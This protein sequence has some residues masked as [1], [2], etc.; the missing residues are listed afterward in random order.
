MYKLYY[1]PSTASL[2]VH[3]MLIELKVDFELVLVDFGTKAQK[4]AE[5][6]RINPSGHVPTLVL[7]GVPHFEC[8]ALLML[9][10]ERH[11]EAGFQPSIGTPERP[12][13]FQ[14]MFYLANTLQPAFRNWFY[15]EEA[16]G[17]ENS[18]A[19][20]AH[21]RTKIEG[22]WERLDKLLQDGRPFMLGQRLTALDFLAT[23]LTRWSRNMPVPATEFPR[24]AR[25]VNHMRAMPSLREVHIREN[26]TDWINDGAR[27]AS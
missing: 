14:W 15:P 4:S 26:L 9:L 7:D 23:M 8:A 16:A 24:V 20:M 3:W 2:A 18:A 22:A 21:A 5:Y 6:L 25:Y 1:A 17:L 10:A 12:A 19:T 11:P 13:Y 27:P